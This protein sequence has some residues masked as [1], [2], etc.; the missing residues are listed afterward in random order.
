VSD[1]SFPA[2]V[3]VHFLFQLQHAVVCLSVLHVQ[4]NISQLIVYM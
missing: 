1:V 3:L 4:S 2:V